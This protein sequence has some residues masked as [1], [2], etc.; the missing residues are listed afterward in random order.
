MTG[1]GV[2]DAPALRHAAIGVALSGGPGTAVARE[3]A[4]LVLTDGDLGVLV[5]AIREGR[6]IFGNL[7]SVVMYLLSG[8]V[9]E[10]AVVGGSLLLLPELAVP[11]TPVQLLWINVVTDGLPAIVLGRDTP[12]GDPLADAPRALHQRL[13]DGHRMRVIAS[14]GLVLAAALLVLTVASLA[15]GIGQAQLG[16]QMMLGLVLGQLALPYVV[17]SRRW[18]L[19]PGWSRNPTLNRVLLASLA[20]QVAVFLTPAGRRVL[21]LHPL[22]PAE[23]AATAAAVAA[24]LVLMEAL[25]ALSR[26]RSGD[27]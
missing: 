16:T 27:R 20:L 17:R 25:R 5:N 13:L 8:N 3:A 15:A 2:N 1:D 4:D 18:A 10:V 6:R 7:V 21:D 22:T 14:R 26:K 11:L 9:A 12:P 23:W 19:E 24:A